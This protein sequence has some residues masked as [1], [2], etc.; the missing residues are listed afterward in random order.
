MLGSQEV[1]RF[2]WCVYSSHGGGVEHDT[3][4]SAGDRLNARVRNLQ[5]PWHAFRLLEGLWD[6]NGMARFMIMANNLDICRALA[7]VL[8]IL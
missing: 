8:D 5:L 4:R 6:R 7:S 2:A 1:L 3:E